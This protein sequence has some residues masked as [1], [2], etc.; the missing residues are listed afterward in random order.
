MALHLIAAS[1]A[2]RLAARLIG[3]V[4]LLALLPA[5]V[6]AQNGSIS[7]QV[8]DAVTGAPVAGITVRV[9]RDAGCQ[10]AVTQSQG[11]YS[12]AVVPDTYWVFTRND[13]GYTNE[14]YDDILRQSDCSPVDA[15]R[16]GPAAGGA[17][18][19]RLGTSA[20]PL[21]RARPSSEPCSTAR[22]R[23]RFGV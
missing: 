1:P 10:N 15:N 18:G 7:G 2:P 14:I 21:I 22:P 5:L 23:S 6:E 11:N 9:C 13:I 8:R 16:S 20:S 12:L 4:A 19:V 17:A 3:A